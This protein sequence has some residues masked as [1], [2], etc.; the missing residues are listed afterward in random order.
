MLSKI[1]FT[2]KRGNQDKKKEMILK[3]LQTKELIKLNEKKSI[4]N[5]LNLTNKVDSHKI[6]NVTQLCIQTSTEIDIVNM[7]M[8]TDTDAD[9]DTDNRGMDNSKMGMPNK[10]TE[11][12]EL[13]K[14]YEGKNV[15]THFLNILDL[16]EKQPMSNDL[17]FEEDNYVLPFNVARI[18]AKGANINNTNMDM[19]N[20]EYEKNK[21]IVEMCKLYEGKNVN[22]HF[23]NILDLHEKHPMSNDLIFEEDNYVVPYNVERIRAKCIKI[24]NNVYQSKYNFGR[25]NCTGLGDFIRGSYFILEF[26]DEYN[27]EPKIVFNNYIAKFLRTKTYNLNLIHNV[28][29]GIQI[30][31]NN[32]FSAYNIINNYIVDPKKDNKHIMAEFVDYVSGS[33]CHYG[34]AF[35][36]CNSFPRHPTLSV[37][38]KEYMRT[39]LEPIDEM[40]FLIQHT[41]QEMQLSCKNYIVIHIRA[42]D[43][44]LKNETDAFSDD[45]IRRLVSH[46]QFDIHRCRQRGSTNMNHMNQHYLLM[47]DNNRIKTLLHEYFPDFKMVMKPITHF[48]EG[49]ILEEEKVINTLLDFYLLSFAGAIFSYS[50]YEHGSGFSYWCAKTFDIPYQCKYIV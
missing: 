32:N 43:G 2:Y 8:N 49:V 14:L 5:C 12:V 6:Q 1:N 4:N 13:C 24:I 26:C 27:F 40:K 50:H 42:G 39:M 31:K 18:R 48:G 9:T 36:F 22:T 23:L 3:E 11:I 17:I 16:Y 19:T 30:F 34:N 38:N 37:K 25:A 41:L 33:V 15:N 20:N 10:T 47:A 21:E 35:V 29:T 28:L 7:G 45:Y 46:I 44:Y